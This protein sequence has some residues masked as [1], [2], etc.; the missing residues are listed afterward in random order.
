MNLHERLCDAFCKDF[1]IREVPIGFSVKTPFRWH[2]GDFLAFYARKSSEGLR[3][4]DDGLTISELEGA[5]VDITSG[6]RFD[7]L[8]AMLR[9]TKVKYDPDEFLFYTDYVPEERAGALAIS[10]L[11]FMLRVQDFLF[12]SRTRTANTFRDD[13]IAALVDRFGAE[14]V[15]LNEAPVSSLSYYVVDIV[16]HC[17]GGKLAAIFPGTTEAKALE[18]VLFSKEIE[19]KSVSN[20]VPFLIYEDSESQKVSR[21]TKSKALNSELQMGDWGGG[22]LDVIDKVEKHIKQVSR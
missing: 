19:L 13:L 17:A 10:F 6:T 11:E 1:L 15:H 22:Q 16:V 12:T 5:G 20:V 8:Q 3:F 4:E 14:N 21:P 18:A 2:S 9:S 7:M